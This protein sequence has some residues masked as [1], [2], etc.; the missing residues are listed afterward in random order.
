M[1]AKH[2][3][4]QG[5]FLSSGSK[6]VATKGSGNW[7]DSLVPFLFFHIA[8]RTDEKYSQTSWTAKKRAIEDEQPG[9]SRKLTG[10]SK[11]ELSY[12]KM[13]SNP[14]ALTLSFTVCFRFPGLWTV[15]MLGQALYLQITYLFITLPVL[16][17]SVTSRH[18]MIHLH[19]KG[20]TLIHLKQFL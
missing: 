4:L 20:K 17:G 19:H 7:L 12:L 2:S 8:L 15:P 9:R 6:L 13:T 1:E 11:E 18:H 10:T 3:I 14:F 16:Y 5:S